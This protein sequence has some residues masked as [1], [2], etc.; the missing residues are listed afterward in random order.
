MSIHL[1]RL[2]D[3]LSTLQAPNRAVDARIHQALGLPADEEAPRYTG[4]LD[5]ARQAIPPG[6]AWSTGVTIT[7]RPCGSG[8]VHMSHTKLASN[9]GF[10]QPPEIALC[11]AA[12]RAIQWL[13]EP[14][15]WSQEDHDKAAAA[16]VAMVE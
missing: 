1:G 12:M 13:Q 7:D 6:M 4:S 10:W 2:I 5:A 15:C 14:G 11:E 3:V 9:E 16:A 8:H